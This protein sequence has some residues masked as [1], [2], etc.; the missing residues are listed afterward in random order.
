MTYRPCPI[1]TKDINL[2]DDLLELVERLAAHNHDIWAAQRIA[3]GW[4]L[5]GERNDAKKQHPDLV[6]YPDL[7]ESEKVY[8]RMSV[9]STLQAILSL[10]Y[11]I[12][13]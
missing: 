3:E 8:D 7:P 9:K 4:S 10:G 2:S 13:R 11:R 5:G 12:V 1:D 6:A